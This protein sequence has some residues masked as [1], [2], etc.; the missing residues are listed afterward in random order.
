MVEDLQVFFHIPGFQRVLAHPAYQKNA[1]TFFLLS[2]PCA[3]GHRLC[4]QVFKT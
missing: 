2:G 3:W 1:V 4:M